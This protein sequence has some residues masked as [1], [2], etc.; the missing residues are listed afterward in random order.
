MYIGVTSDLDK[1][2][3]EHKNGLVK[4]TKG[5]FINLVYKEQIDNKKKAW[6]RERF[7]KSGQCREWIYNNIAV[8]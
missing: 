7:L 4:S 6:K 1:R 2:I 8:R 3:M 5:L